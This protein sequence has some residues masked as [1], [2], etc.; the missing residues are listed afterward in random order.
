MLAPLRSN[1]LRV[2][3]RADGGVGGFSY[4]GPPQRSG[5]SIVI[6]V[7][8]MGHRLVDLA[9][10]HRRRSVEPLSSVVLSC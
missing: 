6:R 9:V 1:R 4:W 10:L 5:T 3:V 2:E 7:W 8:V